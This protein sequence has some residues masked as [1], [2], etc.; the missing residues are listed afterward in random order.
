[1]FKYCKVNLKKIP[2]HR[3]PNLIL[4][5]LCVVFNFKTKTKITAFK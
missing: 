1:M 5:C 3:E 2:L 4:K